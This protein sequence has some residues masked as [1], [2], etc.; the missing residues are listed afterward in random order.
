MPYICKAALPAYKTLRIFYFF[1]F[2]YLVFVVVLLGLGSE[3]GRKMIA[4]YRG[5]IDLILFPSIFFSK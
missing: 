5:L 1:I 4:S 2:I 3:E